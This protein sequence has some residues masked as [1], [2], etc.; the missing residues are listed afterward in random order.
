MLVEN[1]EGL[2]D[3]ESVLVGSTLSDLGVELLVA[4]RL[5][6]LQSLEGQSWGELRSLLCG[7]VVGHRKIDV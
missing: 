3:L 7:G 1:K 2:Q 5:L 6:S 4:E